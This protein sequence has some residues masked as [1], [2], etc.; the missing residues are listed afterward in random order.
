M[1][2]DLEDFSRRVEPAPPPSQR[3]SDDDI[4]EVRSTAYEQGYAAGF[5]DA[6]K[7][8]ADN[9]T[10][11]GSEFARHLQEMSFT[12]HEARAHVIASVTPLLE[13]LVTTFLPQLTQETM[14]QR[15]M[16]TLQPLIEDA[17]DQP[18]VIMVPPGAREALS[19]F[20][21]QAVSSVIR[22]EEE[23]TLTEGQSFLRLGRTERKI[24]L[25]AAFARFRE[26]L[27][28]LTELNERALQHG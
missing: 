23:P 17:G 12:F 10:R 9:Q 14:G 15:L 26:S 21:D 22:I 6:V 7:S 4:A 3:H 20:F 2:L 5:D 27:N 8:E 19:P 18:I 13:E 25:D 1:S 28:A 11:I 16:E 24:D